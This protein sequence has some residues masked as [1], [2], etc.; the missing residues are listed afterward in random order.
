MD[1]YTLALDFLSNVAVVQMWSEMRR[2]LEHTAAK[3]PRGWQLPALACEAVGGRPEQAIPAVATIACA[4][5]SIILIDDLL[6]ADPRG[7]HQRIGMPAVANLAAAF[8]AAAGEAIMRDEAT[9][10]PVARLAAIR[11]V[12]EMLLITAFGQYL[13]T[14]NP[15]DEA[16]Y[17]RLA[18]TKSA[19]FFGAAL[20][21]GALLGGA[22][23]EIAE[24]LK[25][26]G[27]LYGQMIQIHDD[28]SDSM[29]VPANPDWALGRASLPILFAQTVDHPDRARFL[30]LREA[31]SDPEALTEAQTILI[32]CGAISYGIHQLL[33]RYRNAQELLNTAPLVFRGGLENLLEELITP[34]WGLLRAAGVAEPELISAPL[35]VTAA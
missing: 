35:R 33:S 7:E 24:Q 28:L 16:G 11:S 29:A 20:Q 34:V 9:C 2:L 25:K 21:I 3:K 22:P 32:R 10:D 19:P 18:E 23:L 31:I 26:L 27:Y 1:S 30:E 6:D 14:Q 5:I 8:Q 4:Q 12:S 15:A 13:D 17:W